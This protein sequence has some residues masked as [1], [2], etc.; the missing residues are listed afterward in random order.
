MNWTEIP[1]GLLVG[2]EKSPEFW[3]GPKGLGRKILGPKFM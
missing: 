1:I 3:T 2:T